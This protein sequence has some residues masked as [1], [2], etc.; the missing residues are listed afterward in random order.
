[1]NFGVYRQYDKTCKWV[2][3]YAEKNYIAAND[4]YSMHGFYLCRR[5]EVIEVDILQEQS[6]NAVKVRVF[7][8]FPFSFV[9]NNFKM[10]DTIDDCKIIDITCQ[11]EKGFP[12]SMR[13]EVEKPLKTKSVYEL[14]EGC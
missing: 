2:P 11:G 7:Y 9:L 5:E 8:W 13:V 12:F 6:D 4:S 14:L 1:M 10:G 3:Q